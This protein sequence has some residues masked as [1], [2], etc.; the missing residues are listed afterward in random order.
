MAF[1]HSV[2][3]RDDTLLGTCYALGEDFA[4]NPFYL[5]IFISGLLF[6]SPGAAAAVYAGLTALVTLSRWIAPDQLPA[7]S[8]QPSSEEKRPQVD[9]PE[10]LPLA[11]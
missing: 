10:H 3:A 6:Y 4:F 5:R 11:A 8:P 2:V 7:E 1:A 9:R